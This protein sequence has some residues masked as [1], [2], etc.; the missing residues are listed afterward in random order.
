[1]TD[2]PLYRDS[3]GILREMPSASTLS[4][5]VVVSRVLDVDVVYGDVVSPTSVGHV[6]LAD[7]TLTISE[8]TAL[9][10]CLSVGVIGQRI[11]ILVLGVLSH[12]MF[13]VFDVN[14]QLYLD[15]SGGIT[16]IRRVDKFLTPI[17]KCLGLGEI[18]VD[19][20]RPTVLG[21]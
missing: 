18:L 13:E 21:G 3:L 9:G 8:A 4:T 6:G 17:G 16:N 11:D 1:M 2:R 7:A 19:V 14:D 5:G 10:I 12:S 20:G 15:E